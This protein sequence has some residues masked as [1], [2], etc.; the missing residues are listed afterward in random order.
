MAFDKA[1][2]L[3]A[4]AD[5]AWRS[6]DAETAA[7]KAKTRSR[8]CRSSP[9]RAGRRQTLQRRA[10]RVA[11][12]AQQSQGGAR[13]APVRCRARGS[14][15]G[16]EDA[17]Q[18]QA[19]AAARG[20]GV[21]GEE[22]TR[23][24]QSQC[25]QTA[26][27]GLAKQQ[28]GDA[29]GALVLYRQ[30]LEACPQLCAAL[31]NS[32]AAYDA[33]GDKAAAKQAAAK[34]LSCDPSDKDI[35]SI[36]ARHGV[37]PPPPAD[38]KDPGPYCHELEVAA[39]TLHLG[40][41]PQGGDPALQADARALPET[42]HDDE[43]P[44]RRPRSRPATRRPARPISPP[45]SAATPTTRRSRPPRPSTASRRRRRSLRPPPPSRRRNVDL[46]RH[47]RLRRT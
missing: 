6:G 41:D 2:T 45:R 16:Q 40:G 4:E 24:R 38:M 11:G 20:D 44:R 36:A 30:A 9:P 46:L 37:A 35:R 23:R 15:R 25:R 10:R 33:T 22:S 1:T 14:R 19:A 27:D 39:V 18:R 29:P 12:G 31:A 17:R 47:R 21:E 7:Q 3:I 26:S 13:Q 8:P 5:Q 34:A 42:L 43:R 32:A 28:A